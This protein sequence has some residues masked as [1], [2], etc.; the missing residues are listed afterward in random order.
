[1]HRLAFLFCLLTFV[2]V[3]TAA[4]E[5][6]SL[7]IALFEADAT[8]PLGTPVA[9]KPANWIVDPLKA[10]GFVLVGK[11]KPVA[12]ALARD[13]IPDW[14]AHPPLTG[15]LAAPASVRPAPARGRQSRH[16]PGRHTRVNANPSGK[17]LPGLGAGTIARLHRGRG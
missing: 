5:E 9:Y 15:F 13:E 2:P 3:R 8:P 10:R 4:Q 14:L 11:G 17:E 12:L 1:M 16:W 7:S 6:G